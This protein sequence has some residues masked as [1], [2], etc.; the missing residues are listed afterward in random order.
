MSYQ[1]ATAKVWDG[2][3]WVAATGGGSGGLQWPTV[4]GSAQNISVTASATPHTKGAWTELFAST[5][6]DCDLVMVWII[7]S[8][9]GTATESLMDFGT[10]AAGA[11]TV[12]IADMVAGELAA[13]GTAPGFKPD[14]VY[15][16]SVTAGTR[17]AARLQSVASSRT[18]QVWM[19]L[20]S[21]G[22]SSPASLDTIGANTATSRGTNLPT[23]NTYVQLTA[24]TSQAY[25]AIVMIPMAA[26]NNTAAA[27]STYT[28][29]YGA[30]GAEVT[31]G[32]LKVATNQTEFTGIVGDELA[33]VRYLNIP[34]GTRLAVKQSVGAA[35]RDVILYGVPA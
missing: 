31:I 4:V 33:F 2:T 32:T 5:P 13:S 12:R 15:P 35:V 30:A 26:T 17:I 24:S 10:G 3:Q 28:L 14:Q 29:G 6:A 9:S 7:N 22:N 19:T 16:I 25:K 18:A 27:S 23:S 34:A 11:E 1:L 20:M 8:S 21:T